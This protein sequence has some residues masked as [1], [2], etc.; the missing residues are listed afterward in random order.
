[1]S[2][3][4]KRD[5]LET[6]TKTRDWL[7]NLERMTGNIRFMDMCPNNWYGRLD[8]GRA[9][10]VLEVEVNRIAQSDKVMN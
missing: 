7:N 9:I 2:L 10:N 3:Q 8:I 1:M 6:L 4:Q 5:L